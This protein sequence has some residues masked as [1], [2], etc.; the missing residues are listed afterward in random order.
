MSCVL[1]VGPRSHVKKLPS[2]ERAAELLEELARHVQPVLKARGWKVLKLDEICCCTRGR[3]DKN[4]SVGG[5]CMP[6]GDG[7]TSNRIALRLRQPK[8]H[9]LHPFDHLMRVL[10]HE[11]TH[12]VHGP[13]SA[14]FYKLMGELQTQYE[15]LLAQGKVLDAQGMPSIGGR[16]ADP[17]RHNPTLREG[18]ANAA[19]AAA[20]RAHRAS[21]M[22][23]GGKLGGGHTLG[24]GAA[25]DWRSR[26]AA[27]NAA[28]AAD[29]RARGWSEAHGLGSD[30]P[31][32]TDVV[33]AGEEEDASDADASRP[34]SRLAAG[35]PPPPPSPAAAAA[36]L[37]M[38]WARPGAD[39]PCG[40]CGPGGCDE[41]RHLAGVAGEHGPP[42]EVGEVGEV[43]KA[44]TPVE[45]I[46]LTVSSD[47]EESPGKRARAAATLSQ[48]AATVGYRFWACPAC[49]LNNAK[50]RD[51][52]EACGT[53]RYSR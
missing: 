23:G 11:I 12:I 17:S 30:N 41:S 7:C 1:L 3:L 14:A 18:K 20:A 6:A 48:A 47:E 38:A 39:C 5:F 25:A 9:E 31:R 29:A 22:G 15:E 36:P 13:H 33:L 8:T 42:R 43:S 26:S 28:M 37:G 4:L 53:W 46:D 16:A 32:D 21:I 52:C 10:V 2:A 50:S 24:G 44:G 19:D 34:P 35:S 27:D 51:R 40:I 49:T 45:C